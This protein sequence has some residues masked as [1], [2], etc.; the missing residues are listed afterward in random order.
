MKGIKHLNDFVNQR[1]NTNIRIITAPHRH[2]LPNTSCIN[3]EV[4]T[5][6]RKLRKFLNNKEN[7]KILE[8]EKKRED[9]TQHGLHLNMSGKDKIAKLLAQNITQLCEDT[10]KIPIVAKWK[11]THKVGDLTN[12]T[13]Y[14]INADNDPSN[15]KE[16]HEHF[17][18]SI[19]P[20]SRTSSRTKRIPNSRSDDFLWT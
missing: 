2:Y 6:N 1:T 7:V 10:K 9:F 5:F 15:N 3:N 17:L 11:T 19:N 18:D 13:N 4:Q 20:G 14:A 8:Q 16:R 12:S